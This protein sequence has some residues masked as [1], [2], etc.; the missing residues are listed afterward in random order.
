MGWAFLRFF[1][2]EDLGENLPIFTPGK[3]PLMLIIHINLKFPL[4]TQVFPVALQKWHGIPMFSRP[5][6]WKPHTVEEK[7]RSLLHSER[8]GEN[9]GNGGLRGVSL[10]MLSSCS[11]KKLAQAERDGGLVDGWF[12]VEDLVF[13]ICGSVWLKFDLT[14][15]NFVYYE[16]ANYL[17]A[18]TNRSSWLPS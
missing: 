12:C 4:K 2:W 11:S 14:W 18:L 17:T 7:L 5:Y 3:Q 13:G 10:L 8:N 9:G 15:L 16:A 1:C 6:P